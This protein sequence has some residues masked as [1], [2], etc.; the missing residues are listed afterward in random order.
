MRGN[1]HVQFL[2]GWARAT[3]PGYPATLESYV[4]DDHTSDMKHGMDRSNSYQEGPASW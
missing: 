4:R 1:S 3:A 2:G